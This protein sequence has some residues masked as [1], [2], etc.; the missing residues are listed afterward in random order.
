[1][2]TLSQ[3]AEV[4]APGGDAYDK[5]A[6]AI[7][8][9]ELHVWTVRMPTDLAT[10]SLCRE[11]LSPQERARAAEMVHA[12]T[13]TSHVVMRSAA[14]L[15]LSRY[16]RL[17][18]DHIRISAGSNGKPTIQGPLGFNIGHS[19]VIGLVAFALGCEVGVDVEVA[20]PFEDMEALTTR[21]FCVEE[22]EEIR[23]VSSVDRPMAFYRCW[24]RKEAYVKALGSGLS[25]P[26]DS[27]RVSIAADEP[28]R[29]MRLPE[30]SS[31]WSLYDLEVEEG[32][33]AA[34]AHPGAARSVNVRRLD[35]LPLLLGR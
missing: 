18:P 5:N 8:S 26:L 23:R 16:L 12:P 6:F 24:T 30:G 29:F 17:P 15:L 10:I 14:R 33:V 19:G 4:N 11:T 32:Y 21:F 25:T 28:V 2:R 9:F 7:T 31:A 3:Q 34:L 1:M 20:R 27:F 22:A 13:R 35:L